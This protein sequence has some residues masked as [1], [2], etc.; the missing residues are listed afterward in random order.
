MTNLSQRPANLSIAAICLLWCG[1]FAVRMWTPWDLM[2]DDQE[3]PAAYVTDVLKNGHWAVQYDWTGRVASKPPML[4][5]LAALASKAVGKPSRLTLQLP[6]AL[7]TLLLALMILTVGA[8]YFG[9]SAGL[10][11]A[12]IYLMSPL[13]LKQVGLLRTDPLFSLFVFAGALAAYK[14]WRQRG[15]WWVF[16]LMAA[17]ATLTKGPLGVA[18]GL[19]GLLAARWEKSPLRPAEEKSS[20]LVRFLVPGFLIYLCIV[21]AW[22]GWAWHQA[23]FG[24]LEKMILEELIG[25][26]INDD[27]SFIPFTKFYQSTLHFLRG[28][29][30]W[31]V[32]TIAGAWRILKRPSPSD[33]QR[34]FERYLLA[35]FLSGIFLFSIPEHQRSVLILP[36]IPAAALIGGREI[37]LRLMRFTPRRRRLLLAAAVALGFLF[38]FVYYGVVRPKQ[39]HVAR[40]GG[41][42]QMARSI[43]SQVGSEFPIIHV[44]SPYALQYH[45]QTLRQSITRQMAVQA[46]SADVAA[47]FVVKDIDEFIE[48]AEEKAPLL[49]TVMQWP[50]GEAQYKILGTRPK[51][52]YAERMRT[53]AGSVMVDLINTRIRDA[54]DGIVLE[55]TATDA[56][57]TFRNLDVE[58]RQIRVRVEPEQTIR[59]INLG[60]GESVVLSPEQRAFDT[61]KSR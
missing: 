23:G 12:I 60:P 38:E 36:L 58:R 9:Q 35:M 55:A 57:A 18:L 6:N 49:H 53:F 14:A 1:V 3:R 52:E 45:L 37:D 34:P 43:T 51:L 39:K 54:R 61:G 13:V 33:S 32:L 17:L 26:A 48:V 28:F 4:T 2:D 5:W 21:G 16:W 22:L 44:D 27:G 47:Y 24:V 11:S 8:R 19:L 20:F 30:P 31:C 59:T 15:N 50:E 41:I 40:S 42:E 7:A 46:I 25:H 10:W 56:S 29:A